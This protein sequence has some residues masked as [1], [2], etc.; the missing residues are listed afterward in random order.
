MSRGAVPGA[1]SGRLEEG[2]FVACHLTS[3][4]RALGLLALGS[5]PVA[6]ASGPLV[7]Q[8]NGSLLVVS[9]L[10]ARSLS[11]CVSIRAV[12]SYL[13]LQM[14]HYRFGEV[15][16]VNASFFPDL[17][18]LIALLHVCVDFCYPVVQLTTS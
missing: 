3:Y 2:Y 6:H 9:L 13:G 16:L 12:L 18:T 8:L 11:P 1:R 14:H 15:S 5:L 10:K 4:S 17:S 7:N